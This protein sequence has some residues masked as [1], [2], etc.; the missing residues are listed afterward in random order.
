MLVKQQCD[1]FVLIVH[2]N[3]NKLRTS[4]GCTMRG[5]EGYGHVV[6]EVQTGRDG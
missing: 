1:C 5:S 6:S 3:E 2:E 4:A